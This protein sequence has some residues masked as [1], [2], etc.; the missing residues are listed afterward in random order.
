MITMALLITA[1]LWGQSIYPTA[2]EQI[3]KIEYILYTQWILFLSYKKEQL[4]H[5]QE[6]G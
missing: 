6:N 4:S 1:K 2:E 5:L 3:K